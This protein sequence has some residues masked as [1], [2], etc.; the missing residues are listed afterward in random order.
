MHTGYPL[1]TGSRFF[2]Y[3]TFFLSIFVEKRKKHDY[4]Y[5]AYLEKT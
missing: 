1:K 4:C 3:V 2:S 5:G